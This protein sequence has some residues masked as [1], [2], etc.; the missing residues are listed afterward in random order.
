MFNVQNMNKHIKVLLLAVALQ[1]PVV[2]CP[3][4]IFNCQLSTA[5]AQRLWTF[6]DCVQYAIDHNI[7]IQQQEVDILLQKNQLN[8]T[9]NEWLPTLEADA[10]HRFSFGNALASTGTMA[11]SSDNYEADL[12]YTNAS[13]NLSMPIFDGFRRKNQ[14]HADH[15]SVQQATASLDYA[16]KSLTI[17]IATYYLQ[18]L[19][20]RGLAEVAAAEVE[21]SRKLCEKTKSLVDDGRKPMSD[22]AEAEAQLAADEFELTEARGRYRIALLT[23]AQLLN[24]ETAE[25]FDIADIPSPLDASLSDV[26]SPLSTTSFE[27][28]IERYPSIIAGKALVEKSR[29]DIATARAAYYPKLDFRASLNTYYLNFFD[30]SQTPRFGSQWWNN[31]S[32]VVGLHL[33]IPIFDH[34]TTRNNIRKAK[35][36]LTKNRLALDDSRQQLRKE[37]EQAYYNAVNAQSKYLSAKKSEAASQISCTYEQDK[38]EAGRSNIYDLTQAQQRLRRAS[39]NAVQAKYEFVI[40]QKILDIYSTP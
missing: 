5:Q 36:T 27:D 24:L 26:Q 35:M 21:T 9:Q 18:T 8:T 40:R 6:D 10:A 23:L 4:S 38:Y 30:D 29:Y 17:Q 33:H 22:L 19:Y 2:N 37:I 3:F 25:G 34:F 7:N 15:W 28:I 20:E 12:A 16:R 11:S 13:V 1:F 32:E 14:K 39:E 31:K